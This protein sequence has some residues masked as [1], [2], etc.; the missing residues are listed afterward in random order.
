MRTLSG[1]VVDLMRT[2]A[3]IAIAM[4]VM[5]VAT[6]GYTIIAARLLGPQ[7]YGAFAATMNVLLVVSVVS[8]GLQ[9]TAARRISADP[10]HVHQIQTQVLRV[11]TRA[12][13]ALGLLLLLLAPAINVVLKL[14]N[15]AMA[16][17][18]SLAA[19]PMTIMG[20]QA[21]TL[22][23][24]RR[25]FPLG[26]LYI[27]AGAP[28][29]VIGTA[30]LLWQPDEFVAVLAVALA[31]VAPVLVGWWALRHDREAGLSSATHQGRQ[32][33]REALQNS[34]ALFA[35]FM[36][37]NVDLI[38]ARNVLSEHDAGLYGGGL[39]L[40]KAM[41]F[42]PQFVV[43]VAFPSM[44]TT[45][46]RRQALAR[47]LGLVGVMGLVG[48]VAAW[49]LSGLALK[50]VGGA[51]YVEIQ[52]ELWLFAILGTAL[53]MLQLVVY[54]VIARQGQRSVYLVWAALVALV[55]GGLMT[56]SLTSLLLWVALVDAGLLAV[57]V[58][59][60]FYLVAHPEPA[61]NAE[62]DASA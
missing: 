39:I 14:D 3:G 24:E 54:S 36:L 57:L 56:T 19:V 15:L 38:V 28:R 16:A 23:G 34:Q 52:D 8:L 43:I 11:T 46:G 10:Q 6:Y 7:Q 25:W 50:F 22:Q 21:G 12:A 59:I 31:S 37:S 33:A 27:A 32:V 2:G 53:S 4:G 49:L 30:L 20:G 42:L 61:E 17:L 58:A 35:F 48:T 5:N 9:T 41:L 40:A 44:S 51:E 47:S 60:S 55:A 45:E 1:R 26:V 18:V 13:L 29:L 62:V